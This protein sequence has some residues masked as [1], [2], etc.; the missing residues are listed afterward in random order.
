MPPA[1]P[2]AAAMLRH[3]GSVVRIIYLDRA[4]AVSQRCVRID[5]AA[6]G[7]IRG[8]CLLRRGLRLFDPDRILAFEP[9]RRG[10]N[11]HG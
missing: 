10:R 1:S 4:G 8:Y 5:G 2:L 7:K 6:G 3:I 11:R 9:V